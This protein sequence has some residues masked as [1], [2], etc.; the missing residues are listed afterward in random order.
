MTRNKTPNTLDSK[1]TY[2]QRP[3]LDIPDVER[4]EG[5][6][7]KFMTYN[8]LAQC[9]IKRE[10]FPTSGGAL[11]KA[12]RPTVLLLEIGGYDP[13]VICLQEVD[14]ELWDTFWE[15]KLFKMGYSGKFDKDTMKQ[16]GI[17]IAWK[18]DKFNLGQQKTITYDR[19]RTDG[20]ENT[21]FTGCIGQLVSL[22]LKQQIL[23]EHPSLSRNGVIVGTTHLYWHPLGT[24]E[25]TRQA[26][27]L[28]QQLKEFEQQ[29]R[30]SDENARYYR[31]LAGDFNTQPFDAPYLSITAKP[32]KY[33]GMARKILAASV[34]NDFQDRSWREK[35]MHLDTIDPALDLKIDEL[36][37]LHNELDL[38]S[39]SLY[40]LAYHIV[41]PENANIDNDRN[42]PLIS[43][44]AHVWLG[45]LDYIFVVNDWDGTTSHAEKVESL[46]HFE[47]DSS[48][49]VL[50]LLRMPTEEEM[51]PRELTGLPQLGKYP[52]DHL[53]LM[54]K[55]ELL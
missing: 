2:I 11:K 8:V 26:Y 17:A 33:E 22:E 32:V 16:H 7:M 1:Y 48:M 39:T 31:F 10:R 53:C 13:D 36:Q 40:S 46:E 35:P 14:K 37:K 3:M 24:F 50:S 38:R 5:L 55:V 12:I 15:S 49:R 47:R 23:D 34:A 54:A 42:E 18:T 25:R 27:I 9:L 30:S 19:I 28:L 45:L 20:A 6:Q 43:N 52:S 21:A 4:G 29:L 51:G 44:W 41:H